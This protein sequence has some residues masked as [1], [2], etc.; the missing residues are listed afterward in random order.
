MI[1]SLDRSVLPGYAWIF[2]L[3]NN[4]YNVGCGIFYKYKPEGGVNLGEMLGAFVDQFSPA[5]DLLSKGEWLESIHGATLRCGLDGTKC[6]D[7]ERLLAVG[8]SIGST[9]SFTGEGIGKAM[10]TAEIAAEMI[11][12]ALSEGNL[13]SL[14]SYPKVLQDRLRS[15]YLGYEAAER[16]MKSP[17]FL[18]LVAWR[19]QRSRRV[20]NALGKVINEEIDLREAL[21]WR[22]L[23]KFAF[24]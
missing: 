15:R 16:W 24:G 7:G 20:R 14:Y 12:S 19:G 10:E 5:E 17:W 21:S 22:G 1:I 3:P 18:D 8:E 11:S 13:K 23:I 4:I 9:F 6:M 2:P